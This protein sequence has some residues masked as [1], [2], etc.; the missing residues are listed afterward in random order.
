MVRARRRRTL[1]RRDG[2]GEEHHQ[3]NHLEAQPTHLL[4]QVRV[5]RSIVNKST[6]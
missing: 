1:K 4:A 3:I 2:E 6:I 5:V